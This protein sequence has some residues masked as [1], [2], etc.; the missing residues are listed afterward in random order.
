MKS[1]L[2]AL[3]SKGGVELGTDMEEE[4]SA[5]IQN[6]HSDIESLSASDFR[7]IFWNQQVLI[8]FFQ[9]NCIYIK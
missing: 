2:D 9:H 1:H 5:I 3:I 4:M 7:R 8:L 6:H